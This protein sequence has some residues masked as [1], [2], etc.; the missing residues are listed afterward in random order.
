MSH[1]PLF[2]FAAFFN[3]SVGVPFFFF[4]PQIARVIGMRPIP[5]DTLFVQISAAAII[6]FGWA[7]WMIGRDPVTYRPYILLGMIGKITFVALIYANW[8]AGT[9]NWPLPAIALGD[10]VFTGLFWRYYRSSERLTA[11]GF[12]VPS[13]TGRSGS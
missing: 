7:Y 2:V 11:G 8:A 4:A 10:L 12:Q 13:R 6:L 3:W 9:T 1:R 5:S